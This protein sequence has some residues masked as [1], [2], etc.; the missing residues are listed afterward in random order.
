M[1]IGNMIMEL[2]IISD[3]SIREVLNDIEELNK[4]GYNDEEIYAALK[5]YYINLNKESE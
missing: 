5:E 2:V 4:A 1:N 3:K